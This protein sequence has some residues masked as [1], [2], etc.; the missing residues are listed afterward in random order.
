VPNSKGQPTVYVSST[1]ND[2]EAHRA[3]LKTALEKTRY[4]VECMEK[5]TAFDQRPLDRCLADVAATDVYVLLIAHRYGYRPPENNPQR[6]SITQLEYEQASRHN[7]PRLVFTIHSDHDWKPKWIDSGEDGTDL[8]AFRAE[9]EASHGVGSFTTADQLASLVLQALQAL[10]PPSLDSGSLR[11]RTYTPADLQSWVD[12]HRDRLAEA[13]LGLSTVQTRQVHVPLDVC[14][15]PAGAAATQGPRLLRPEDLEPLLAAA[16]SH[17]LLLSGDGGAGKTSLAFAIARWWQEGEPGGVVRL[18]VLIETALGSKETVADRVRSW[19]R[20]Q[21][22][23]ATE[24]ELAPELVEA[25]LAAKRL[26]PIVD[27]LSELT[28]AAREQLLAALPAGLVLV[29]S[30]SDHDRFPERPLSLIVPQRIGVERLQAFFLDYLRRKGQGEALSDDDLMPAQ[31]QLKRIVG[32]KPITVLLAQMFIDDVIANREQGLLAG[33]VP[34]L[35]LSYVRRLDTPADQALRRRAGLVISEALVQR[36]LRVVALASH[37]QGKPSQPLFQPLEFS[38]TLARSAVMVEEPLGLGL[39]REQAEALLGYLIELRLL[40]Q[41]GAA[42]GRLRFPLDPLAD[43]L[44]AAEQF[45]RLEEQA[46]EPA[47]AVQGAVV[48]E[49][50]LAAL[51]PRPEAERERM[52]GFLLALRDGAMEAQGKRA[53]VMPPEVPDRLAALGF[54]DAEGERYR[55]ALQ[56]ARKWMWELGVPVA[57]ERR[58]AIAKL[59]AMAAA[60]EGSERRAARDVASRRLARMLAE[61]LSER[62]AERRL[63]QQDAAVVLGLIG[64]EIGIEALE[65]LASDGSQ[66]PE[67]RRAALES[68]GLVA[69][70]QAEH[71]EPIEAFLEGQL[72]ADA[73]DLLVEGEEGWAEHDRHLPPLQGASRGLQLAASAALP[74]LGS[75]PGRVV[76]MLTLTALQEGEGLRIRTEVVTPPVWRLPLPEWPGEAPQQL[77]LVVVEGGEAGIGS[78]ETEEGRDWYA[79]QREG[80]KGVNVEAERSVRLERFALMRHAI[81]QAQWQAVAMLPQLELDLNTTPGTYKPDDLWE[82]FAQPG[83]LPVDSVSWNDCQEWLGRLNRW[84]LEQW[85]E[86]GGQGDAPQLALPGEGQWEVACRAG[87]STPFHFGDALDASWVN[88]DGGYTYGPGRK[89][90][91]RLRPVS[92]GFFGLVNRWGLAEMHGQLYEWCGDQWHPDPTAEGWSSAGMPW[93]GVDPALEALGTAQKELKLLRGGSWFNVP[94]YCR[95]AFRDGFLP[96]LVYPFIGVRPCCLLPPGS[97]LGP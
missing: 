28:P 41:P 71:R 34:E 2:L 96:A 4:D 35:M 77:E 38:D 72:R 33:S 10:R 51:E 5:Y 22:A 26:I 46:L 32:D 42:V 53:L 56:R 3:A 86:L 81:T 69:R 58:D 18:P 75:A 89:G 52:Q 78:P 47:A 57:S 43:H 16:G 92:V 11:T 9:V 20:N 80:C 65:R 49:Q 6:R 87:A 63:E 21:L 8:A 84:L 74:L 23:N 30:R 54:L 45:E 29:T 62:Q 1:F 73:L 94:H 95:A 15:T 12:R 37:R 14:L 25:L 97:L 85:S 82:R 88:Y 61:V 83:G 76:P 64:A 7:K 70:D 36:A 24:Q 68:L 90:A 40:L 27:H 55:L 91:Y 39:S 59:A 67:L 79:N 50:F 13:F 31:A 93:Q 44:A 66:P 19:L 60:P 48:W 17:V